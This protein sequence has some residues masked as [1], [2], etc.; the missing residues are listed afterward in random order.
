MPERAAIIAFIGA[1]GLGLVGYTFKKIFADGQSNNTSSAPYKSIPSLSAYTS[2]EKR[3]ALAKVSG[4]WTDNDTKT[5]VEFRLLSKIWVPPTPESKS[6]TE[7][8]TEPADTSSVDKNGDPV[9]THRAVTVFYHQIKSKPAFAGVGMEIIKELLKLLD[10]HGDCPS[11]VLRN[12]NEPD[13]KLD[14]KV[15]NTLKTKVSLLEHTLNVTQEIMLR[16]PPGPIVPK[17]VIAALAHDIGKIPS[18]Y[19][20]MYS[21]GDHKIVGVTVLDSLKL[22]KG[23]QYGDDVLTAIRRHHDMLDKE[24]PFLVQALKD[25]D[26]SAR[27][28]E[29]AMFMMQEDEDIEDATN[30]KNGSASS[31]SAKNNLSSVAETPKVLPQTLKQFKKVN[32]ETEVAAKA[33]YEKENAT[34][35][36]QLKSGEEDPLGNSGGSAHPLTDEPEAKK[37]LQRV[38]VADWLD[39]NGLINDLRKIIHTMA[40]GEW[41][42]ISMPDGAVYYKPRWFWERIKRRHSAKNPSLLAADADEKDKENIIYSVVCEMVERGAINPGQIWKNHYGAVYTV[43][44]IGTTAA[45]DQFLIPVNTEVF[46]VTPSALE[47]DKVGNF[48]A[49]SRIEKKNYR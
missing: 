23:L 38:D 12:V 16:L 24:A 33:A 39:Y 30:Q 13:K 17:G 31:V 42:A 37:K 19:D 5:Y 35:G 25:A 18:F 36:V 34:G 29:L 15:I 32:K 21:T 43:Y 20:K 44:S 49:V 7:A 47:A 1:S 4:I 41:Q 9:F 14:Q 28:Q 3:L 2:E 46:G 6:D 48:K 10:E 27:R 40:S 22:F 45:V 26:Q 11:V 8:V